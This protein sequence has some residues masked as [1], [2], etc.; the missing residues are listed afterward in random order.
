MIHA[1][2][3]KVYTQTLHSV[4]PCKK[5]RRR[6]QKYNICLEMLSFWH[7]T[8][9]WGNIL[10][11]SVVTAVHSALLGVLKRES[12]Q[13]GLS[14]LSWNTTHD[15]KYCKML[16]TLSAC[17]RWADTAAREYVLCY[18]GC[19]HSDANVFRQLEQ[20]LF[21]TGRVT[22]LV[23]MGACHAWTLWIPAIE[24]AITTAVEWELW[25]MLCDIT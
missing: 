23:H 19:S 25:E 3:N 17:N 16:I 4:I 13:Q 15:N 9:E 24:D 6:R 14:E 8:S 2:W 21:E 18:P 1:N 5:K 22:P 11:R 7:A 20:L 12:A 10:L